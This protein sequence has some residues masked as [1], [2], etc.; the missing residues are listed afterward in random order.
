MIKRASDNSRQSTVIS[1]TTNPTQTDAAHC[2]KKSAPIQ[3][4]RPYV[5]LT[6]VVNPT[7]EVRM[8]VVLVEWRLTK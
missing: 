4:F 3:N 8:T 2:Q 1:L 7:S 5:S 6:L